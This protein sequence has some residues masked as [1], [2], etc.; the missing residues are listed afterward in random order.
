MFYI[1]IFQMKILA[2]WRWRGFQQKSISLPFKQTLL[3]SIS[4][5]GRT[6]PN[7]RGQ[8]ISKFGKNLLR[9]ESDLD[10]WLVALWRWWLLDLE[11]GWVG[12][13][14]NTSNR[15]S[16]KLDPI[17]ESTLKGVEGWNQ[18]RKYQNAS[19]STWV[20]RVKK[21]AIERVRWKCKYACWRAKSDS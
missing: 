1:K 7:R 4:W 8:N 6:S 21:L 20:R 18:I 19:K 16:H 12:E 14:H 3:P 11:E 5:K 9:D 2:L 15:K 17:C 10:L 13:Q